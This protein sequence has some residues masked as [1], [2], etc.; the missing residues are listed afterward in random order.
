MNGYSEKPA[1]I[2]WDYYS[3]NISK[4]NLVENF[5]KQF[6]ALSVPYPKDTASAAIEE[7]QKTTVS[8]IMKM[9]THGGSIEVS[10]LI[11]SKLYKTGVVYWCADHYQNLDFHR[12]LK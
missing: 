10:C 3:R 5:Q 9:H 12:K 8:A 1:P 4:P 11:A 6:Q 7:R 2:D